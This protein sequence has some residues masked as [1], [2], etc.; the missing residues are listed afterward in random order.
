[1]NIQL[2]TK[3]YIDLKIIDQHQRDLVLVFPG[4]GYSRTSA[5]ESDPVADVFMKDGYHSAIYYYREELLIYPEIKEEGEHVLSLLKRNP[6]V[7]RIFLIGFSAGAHLAALLMSSYPD[8]V[9]GTILAYPV[10]TSNRK[11][12][13]QG[14][15]ENLLG[16]D[17]SKERLHQVSL[18]HQMHEKVSPVF[19]MHTMDDLSVPVENSLLLIEA[20]KKHHVLVEAHLYPKGRHGL[21][22]ATKET[23]FEDMDPDEFV[24]AY[25]YL[26]GWIEL[27]KN[28]LK[29]I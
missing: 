2:K 21:S 26:S 14:S 8:L 23:R 20:L 29:R 11:Y 18:E 25:G 27:A 5:R 17:L 1:M 13:N 3:N 16:N 28:F 4:G 12:W 10:I 19:I 22:L 15:I 9:S 24:Q 6:L 7:N